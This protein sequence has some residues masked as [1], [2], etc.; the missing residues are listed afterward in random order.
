M[1]S[2]ENTVGFFGKIN[3]SF[4]MAITPEYRKIK[5]AR[6]P[7]LPHRRRDKHFFT[8]QPEYAT[9]DGL[10]I[11]YADNKKRSAAHPAVIEPIT[12]EH[13]LL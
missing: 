6:A 11:R 5:T 1:S 7:G 8:I 9:I 12:P 13:S 3:A 2:S 4:L 10:K